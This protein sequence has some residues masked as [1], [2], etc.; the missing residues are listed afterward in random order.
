MSGFLISD[1]NDIL[2]NSLLWKVYLMH[3]K[4]FTSIPGLYPQDASSTPYPSL[5]HQKY[6]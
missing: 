6:L 2:D 1:T 4:M 5:N 3:F